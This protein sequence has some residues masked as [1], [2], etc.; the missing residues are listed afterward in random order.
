MVKTFT[1]SIFMRIHDHISAPLWFFPN[2]TETYT[3]NSIEDRFLT[4]HSKFSFAHNVLLSWYFHRIYIESLYKPLFIIFVSVMKKCRMTQ[5]Y[6][7][8]GSHVVLQVKQFP[9]VVLQAETSIRS[10]S[11]WACGSGGRRETNSGTK[12]KIHK[13]FKVWK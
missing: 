7:V 8:T 10:S 5:D 9:C 3:N 11:S 2:V 4:A 1:C 13:V 6:M 12:K